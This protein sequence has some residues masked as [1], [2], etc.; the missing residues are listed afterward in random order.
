MSLRGSQPDHGFLY[1]G[2]KKEFIQ[3]EDSYPE[4][5]ILSIQATEVGTSTMVVVKCSD[6]VEE[7]GDNIDA[8]LCGL[9]YKEEEDSLLT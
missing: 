3:I 7:S 6:K 8:P 9:L 5:A 2:G 1:G 4:G